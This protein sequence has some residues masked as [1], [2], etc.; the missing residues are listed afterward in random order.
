MLDRLF[1]RREGAILAEIGKLPSGRN[2][3]VAHR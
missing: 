1:R 3:T 2:F